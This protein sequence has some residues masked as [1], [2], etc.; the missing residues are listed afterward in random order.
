VKIR[1]VLVFTVFQYVS[2]YKIFVENRFL[3]H[4]KYNMLIYV[5]QLL[6]VRDSDG[7]GH[8]GERAVISFELLEV[9]TRS[10]KL[11]KSRNHLKLLK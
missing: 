2:V 8:E 10:S 1:Y 9:S 7:E 5:W 6:G 11:S 4:D 3:S